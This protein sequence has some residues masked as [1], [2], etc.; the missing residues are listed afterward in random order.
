MVTAGCAEDSEIFTPCAEVL[1]DGEIPVRA[2][3]TVISLDNKFSASGGDLSSSVRVDFQDNKGTVAFAG[4]GPVPAF[5]YK[6]IPWP[7]VGFTLYA[8]LGVTDGAWLLF[9]IYCAPDGTLGRFY[10]ERTDATGTL[11][12]VI[13]GTCT[14][15]AT[16]WNMPV[17]APAHTLRNIPMT[18]GFSVATADGSISLG[19]SRPGVA[20]IQTVPATALVFSTTDCRTDCGSSAWFELHSILWDPTRENVA[21]AVW[22]LAGTRSGTGVSAENGVLMPA[23]G[24]ND[25]LSPQATWTLNR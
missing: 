14:E 23:A 13:T 25:I 15:I 8:G 7:D 4:S 12:R 21:F 3:N 5:I 24:W 18:C 17:E 1:F 10:G 11:N 19:S 22:Y 9:W 16:T 6:R 20:S 2:T